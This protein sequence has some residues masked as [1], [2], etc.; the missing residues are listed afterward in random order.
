LKSRILHL[1]RRIKKLIIIFVDYISIICSFY[2]ASYIL[3]KDVEIHNIGYWIV[4]YIPP[5]IAI[6]FYYYSNLYQNILRFMHTGTFFT[7]FLGAFFY[8]ILLGLIPLLFL[9][10][11]SFAMSLIVV[12]FL[13]LIF[14]L[15][16]TRLC[17]RWFLVSREKNGH[18]KN[19]II[20]GAGDAGVQIANALLMSGNYKP[21]AF[22]DDDNE[23]HNTRI[24]D[25]RVYSFDAIINIIN[26][27]DA[28]E[29]LIAIPSLS[30]Q[31]RKNL[32][33][34]L[35]NIAINIRTLPDIDE[36]VSG[37]VTVEDI[38]SIEIEDLLQ[39][40]V[41]K[42]KTELLEKNINN[43]AVLITGAGGSIGSE[44]ARQVLK[45][46]PS[47]I[48]LYEANEYSLYSIEKEIK[49]NIEELQSSNTDLISILGIL[50]NFDTL[51]ELLS[52]YAVNT[53]YHA[54]AYKHVPL[55]EANQV[56]GVRNNI[57]G[58]L[59]IIIAAIQ[60][61]IE[62]FVL[63]STDK[64]VRP[65]S[66]MGATKRFTEIIIQSLSDAK[67]NSLGQ[68]NLFGNKVKPK[69]TLF[70]I[71]RF[72]NVLNSSGSVVPLFKEQ[73][74]NKGP[75]TVTDPNIIRF[76]MSI[77]EAVELV[78]QAGAM[79]K[80]GDIFILDMGEPITILDLA[81]KMIKLSGYGVAGEESESKKSIEIIY[82]GLRPGE[83][84]YEEL[85]INP[86]K[87]ITLHPKIFKTKQEFLSIEDINHYLE[88]L[89]NATIIND[90]MNIYNILTQAIPE[91]IPN[92]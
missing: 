90:S 82:T 15:T 21:I 76:F 29:V 54:A 87:E 77:R 43:K 68:I 11:S 70:S 22:V 3:F 83:K 26:K 34:R 67:D 51:K 49:N 8:S 23:L 65:T 13:T 48:I 39:R 56:Q 38:R 17:A 19:I 60:S 4:I 36:I 16:I 88:L 25:I 66:L 7:L 33:A 44:I 78:I 71:V 2:F 64:A 50:D 37:N 89:H 85:F 92:N 32:F 27:Y 80:G 72:G 74:K 81:K 53:V 40:E 10:D 42:P 28:K 41:I 55:V 75:I 63:I 91:Y 46:K 6:I 73:I 9:N 24:S 30:D 35:E 57:F 69:N 61:N 79:A 59:N 14:L 31:S 84:L 12:N 62:N 1:N 20:Y 86:V 5:V 18:Q 45:Y 58:S 52:R 47:I